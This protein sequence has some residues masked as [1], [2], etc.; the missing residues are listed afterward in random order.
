M[1]FDPET[2]NL[3]SGA[4]LYA[5]S[6]RG[7]YIPRFFAECI[8]LECTTGVAVETLEFLSRADPYET[9]WYWDTW[10]EVLDNCRVTDPG[11]GVTYY[12][13]QDGDLW[14]IPESD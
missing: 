9:D 6:A 7:V 13:H 10:T 2:D 12:L 14:L 5:D 4:I 3:P 1:T 11:N 8:R